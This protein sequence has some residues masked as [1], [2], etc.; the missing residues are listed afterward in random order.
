MEALCI[1]KETIIDAGAYCLKIN[2]VEKALGG[3]EIY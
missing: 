1:G 2:H 3:L